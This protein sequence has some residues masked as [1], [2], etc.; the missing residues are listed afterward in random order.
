[1]LINE[2]IEKEKDLFLEDYKSNLSITNFRKYTAIG[3]DKTELKDDI[4]Y[5]VFSIS[6]ALEKLEEET[7]GQIAS[8]SD[9]VASIIE[10]LDAVL[11]HDIDLNAFNTRVMELFNWYH[12]EEFSKY[13]GPY[14]PMIQSSGMG[15]TR[16]FM[17]LKEQKQHKQ[18][19]ECFTILCTGTMGKQDQ[20]LEYFNEL[21]TTTKQKT[22]EDLREYIYSIL[23]KLI[24]NVNAVSKITMLFDEAQY[25]LTADG[26]FAFR[27]IRWWLRT[28]RETKHVVAVFAGTTSHLTNFYDTDLPAAAFSRDPQKTFW[29]YKE[30]QNN[31]S[32][33]KVY[34]PFFHICTI[35]CYRANIMPDSQE[36]QTVNKTT[37][38]D[39]EIAA[40]YG[41]PLFS[42]LQKNSKLLH[43]EDIQG[44]GVINT[45]LC[46]VMKRML[47]SELPSNWQDNDRARY[48][49]LGTRIQMGVTTSFQF[50]SDLVSHAYANLVFINVQNVD[51]KVQTVAQTTFMPD[52]V[53][54]TLAMGLMVPK[55][56]IQDARKTK[57]YVG[58]NQA[59]WSQ[60][61]MEFFSEGLC[62]P[63]K[64]D[65]G[66]IMTALYMLFCGDI[67]R[68]KKDRF[69]RTFS[70]MLLDCSNEG[71]PNR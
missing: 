49:I 3:L 42:I 22:Q 28:N 58:M 34:P 43:G 39:F 62:I 25:L 44:I 68:A 12:N 15:K 21:I 37:T 10:G 47:L 61:A 36:V 64:G 14:F 31:D 4:I 30:N 56:Q 66:E 29:N 59:F 55:W 70:V 16:L 45:T 2:E 60:K 38:S 19:C 26:G 35:G 6:D 65:I 50:A 17:A 24:E 41:R 40:Y 57:T 7:A 9:R 48:S 51:D 32:K 8:G 33:L 23:D 52:P 71:T 27:C 67:L 11:K 1:M 46:N 13:V 5:G 54:A 53:C 18:C 63:E 20:Y 69:L